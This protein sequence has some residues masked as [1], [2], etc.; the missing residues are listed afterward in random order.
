MVCDSEPSLMR[1]RRR[2]FEPYVVA[3]QRAYAWAE[4][5]ML[6]MS[7]AQFAQSGTAVEK[8]QHWLSKIAALEATRA[9]NGLTGTG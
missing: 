8:V 5:A 2:I 9:R 7:A 3:H 1:T 4:K 6:Y